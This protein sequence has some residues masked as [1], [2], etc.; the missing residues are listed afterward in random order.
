M[1]F[2]S[3]FPS[4][5]G[6]GGEAS[7]CGKSSQLR[8]PLPPSCCC[9]GLCPV[10]G[11]AGRTLL[12]ENLRHFGGRWGE[13]SGVNPYEKVKRSLTPASCLLYGPCWFVFFFFFGFYFLLWFS[14]CSLPPSAGRK[15]ANRGNTDAVCQTTV[16]EQLLLRALRQTAFFL[17]AQVAN[18]ILLS[19]SVILLFSLPREG[20]LAPES[21]LVAKD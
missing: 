2:W 9:A 5:Q 8:A 12:W 18:G 19:P 15:L 7:I 10:A 13:L 21:C 14:H 3:S 6:G 16:L 11:G 4:A 1:A 20:S 17:P